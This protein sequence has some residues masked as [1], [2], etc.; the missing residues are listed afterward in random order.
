VY[1]IYSLLMGL[2]ALLLAPY[3]LAKGLRHGKYLHNLGERLGFSF[4]AMTKLSPDRSGA[5]WIHAVSVGEVL[6]G[7]ALARQL[8]ALYPGR[9]L[10]VSTTTN[11][12]QAVARERLSFADAVIYFPLD[13]GFSVR[14]A[15][16]AVK[17]ALVLILETE[18]WPNFLREAG[19][20]KVPVLFVSGRISDRSYARYQKYLGA[21]G[22]F[23]RPL[24]KDALSHAGTFLMQSG[25]DA[26]RIRALGAP[27]ER[28]SASGSL[29]FDLDLPAPS[30]LSNWLEAE[31]K[32]SGRS[33]VIVAGSVVATEE[34]LA[35]IAFGTLQGEHRN[36]F[37]VLAPRK[38]EQFSAAADF[39]EESHRKFIRRSELPIP[40][41][42]QTAGGA[43][44]PAGNSVLPDGVTV[45]LLDSIGEL[46]SLYRLA[47]GAF[48]GGSLVPSG[49]H[50][51]L[52][53]AAFGKVPVFGP[54]M[55]NFAEIAS[56][57]VSAGAAVQVESPEDV[58]V[59]WIELFRD[60]ARGKRMGETA[61]QLV[62]A[63]RGATDRAL[64]EIAKHLGPAAH[65]GQTRTAAGS[66]A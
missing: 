16:D 57:F 2:A 26:E 50:N 47:D 65:G 7:I 60:P 4:P 46:A 56:R 1:F 5:I 13:W 64:A 10:I 21:F 32:R 30:P 43:N 45:L 11:T 6:S 44:G 48:V 51:I 28:V 52:E 25:K 55:E 12:G 17:P 14:C 18:I 37:L 66:G 42:L 61:R 15:F 31:V 58:G 54:S 33:P 40:G 20:R 62:E 9:P 49:G 59:A 63:S 3:W 34:P 27:T 29:K 41:P 53:P 38:P 39:I 35:L 19:R 24:L 22:L 8:K 36:A 23:L